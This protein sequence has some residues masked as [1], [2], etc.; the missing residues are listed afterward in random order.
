MTM[1]FDSIVGLVFLGI[2]WYATHRAYYNGLEAGVELHKWML[3]YGI[4]DYKEEKELRW[5]LKDLQSQ[6]NRE[7]KRKE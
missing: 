3:K 5:E 6:K 4:K 1:V 7:K 2:L